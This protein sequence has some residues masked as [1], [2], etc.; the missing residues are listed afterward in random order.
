MQKWKA[1]ALLSVSVVLFGFSSSAFAN[2]N[3]YVTLTAIQGHI[4]VTVTETA[5][6]LQDLSLISG[7]GFI[8]SSFFKFHQ[9]KLN[10]TQVPMSQGLTLLII[11][12]CLTLFPIL[13]PTAG[14]T[15]LGGSAEV[16]KVSGSRIADLIGS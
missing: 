16:S 8:L 9:H 15:I 4:A 14:T 6:I 13:V 11:G 1:L 5:K 12:G 3:T 10:P 7:I 2:G